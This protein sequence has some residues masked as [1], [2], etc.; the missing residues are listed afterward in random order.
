MSQLTPRTSFLGA[1]VVLTIG[2]GATELPAPPVRDPLE[3][4]R[5]AAEITTETYPDA[6]HVVVDEMETVLYRADGTW[7][8]WNDSL[9][10]VLTEKGRRDL[11]TLSFPF[12]LHYETVAV[13]RVE[14]IGSDGLVRSIELQSH[15]RVSIAPEQM[16]QNIYDPRRQVLT[17]GIP[18]L[19]TGDLVHAVVELCGLRPRVPNEFF[20]MAFLQ[21]QAPIVRTVYEI[22][23]PYDK[24]LVHHVVRSEVPGTV[25]YELSAQAGHHRHRWVAHNVP[26]LIP[27]PNMPDF[28]RVVQRVL[29][30]TCSN[31]PAISRWYWNLS[32][33]HLDAVDDDLRA[34][35]AELVKGCST[36][37]QKIEALFSFV[38]HHIR[39]LG[40]TLEADAP[41]YEP[42]D[43]ALT[44]HRR[45]G[46]CRD[47]AALLVSMLRL[48]GIE[49]F[50]VLIHAGARLDPDVPLPYFNHA[51]A[52]ARLQT[53][54]IC[55]MD[56]TDETTRDLLPS[57][58]QH[59]SYLLASQD[60]EP[61]RTSPVVPADSNL[62]HIALS[63]TPASNGRMSG[64]AQLRFDGIHDNAFRRLLI[65]RKPDERR[66]IFETALKYAAPGSRLQRFQ[67][68]PEP[69]QQRDV[70]L[71]AVLEFEADWP[72]AGTGNVCVI[73][74]PRLGQWIGL[75]EDTLDT[76]W[77]V[78][79]QYPW[80]H[81]STCGV[82]ESIECTLPC[83]GTQVLGLPPNLDLT[84]PGL[85]HRARMA[86][87]NNW[88]RLDTWTAIDRVELSPADHDR[89]REALAQIETARRRPILVHTPSPWSTPAPPPS[90]SPPSAEPDSEVL[91]SETDYV[92]H[93][94]GHWT[95]TN[96]IIRRIRT[97]AG[98]KTYAEL[99][100]PYLEE[101][102]HAEVLTARSVTADGKSVAIVNTEI[103]TMDQPWS[104]DTPRFP[105]GRLLVVAF[106]AVVPGSTIE[107]RT[108]RTVQRPNLGAVETWRSF[109][110]V[111]HQVLRIHEPKPGV[112]RIRDTTGS[113]RHIARTSQAVGHLTVSTWVGTNLPALA[114]EPRMPPLWMF[115]PTVVLSDGDWATYASNVWAMIRR[116]ASHSRQLRQEAQGWFGRAT[117]RTERIR[118]IRDVVTRRVRL[119]GPPLGELPWLALAPADTAWASGYA[120]P[121]ERAAIFFVL[122]EQAGLH[123]S[124]VLATE[125]PGSCELPCGMAELV[126][127]ELL[128]SALVCVTNEVGDLVLLGDT[129]QYD[130]LGV[131]PHRGRW[132]L[133]LPGGTMQSDIPSRQYQSRMEHEWD[134]ELDVDGAAHMRQRTRHYGTH[135]GE[136]VQQVRETPA[137]ELRREEQRQ[138]F[139]F[140]RDAVSNAPSRYVLDSYP[141]VSEMSSRVPNWATHSAGVW[142]FAIPVE[143]PWLPGLGS[144]SRS[145]PLYWEEPIQENIT[146]RI[147]WSGELGELLHYPEAA[148][149]EFP[150]LG[151][152]NIE[153]HYDRDHSELVWRRTVELAAGLVPPALYERLLELDRA[154]ASPHA[155]TIVL[156]PFAGGTDRAATIGRAAPSAISAIRLPSPSTLHIELARTSA[157]PT[158]AGPKNADPQSEEAHA[159]GSKGQSPNP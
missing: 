104:T 24:P 82:H 98:A 10:K 95:V 140:A 58:L 51:I 159:Q 69:L 131:S 61:L 148:R 64:R 154:L 38:S 47:K 141:A 89:V 99:R 57:Y 147:R 14:I 105:R 78:P 100:I 136:L 145:H 80:E 117:N 115:Q 79:R 52:A 138:R 149:W 137:E 33:P 62:L 29:V 50:P 106:P 7:Q 23:A 27:E 40:L 88:F 34:A 87:S 48:A 35:V 92:I 44:F 11:T 1:A 121:L 12:H 3:W 55:L 102:D 134:I 42:H 36:E 123:P 150:G 151:Q 84:V 122:A 21:T 60:G 75:L 118:A 130:E 114:R 107:Y 77:R 56:P 19:Q 31:W 4:A 93:G 111:H 65:R 110:P 97:Y 30:S 8:G 13:R 158:A 32:R 45:H 66:R 81:Y 54:E 152:V 109:E 156:R 70:P 128:S 125:I 113:E 101:Y 59:R 133:S 126:W 68:E 94:P 96:Y 143:P 90:S 124:I 26:R 5:R 25:A 20:D 15:T 103:Q 129:T 112:V 17:V 37:P 74:P 49:G 85:R 46:V 76:F 2:V 144:D 119:A 71:Q 132:W 6:D 83:E 63:L 116:L 53:G 67:I 18:G 139:L 86:A 22:L 73:F 43:V 157:N 146:V 142:S 155:R 16:G 39:Y 108:V 135:H 72:R 41:G 153:V 120:H 9:F 127:P 28:A 91:R